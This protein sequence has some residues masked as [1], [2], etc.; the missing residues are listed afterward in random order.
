MNYINYELVNR[1]G[2]ITINRPEKRNALNFE[3]VS[4]LKT[5]FSLA[6]KDEQCKVIVLRAVG[7]VFCAGADLGYLQQLQKNTLVLKNMVEGSQTEF[8]L[9]ELINYNF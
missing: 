6:E 3:V 4:E 8:N 9:N 5:T 2:Y 1:I 7:D